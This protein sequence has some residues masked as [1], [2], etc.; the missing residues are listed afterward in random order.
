M[1][2]PATDQSDSDGSSG[3]APDSRR[4]FGRR[5][6]A[7]AERELRHRGY[8]IID[9]NVRTAGG[10]LDLVA[11]VGGTVV[12]VEVRAR[13]SEDVGSPLESVGPQKRRQLTKLATSYLRQKKLLEQPAR[14]DVVAVESDDDGDLKVTVLPD[15][16]PA[17]GPYAR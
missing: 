1:L 16:F 6:E 3:G 15:A 8:R 4:D 10:E 2:T 7:A 14:F 11:L 17:Q 12:F 5:A 13:H 9:R